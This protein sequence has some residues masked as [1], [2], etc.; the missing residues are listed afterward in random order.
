MERIGFMAEKRKRISRQIWSRSGIILMVF[1]LVMCA[2][3]AKLAYLQIA[4]HEYYKELVVNEITMETEVNPERG[5]I[6]DSTGNI[7]ATNKT[8]YLCFIS[9]QDIIDYVEEAT[10]ERAELAA[11]AAATGKEFEDPTMTKPFKTD[12]GEYPAMPIAQGISRFLSDTLDVEYEKILEKTAKNGRRYE[13][14]KDKIDEEAAK[15]IREFIDE[16]DL[17]RMIYLRAGSIRY[18]P[19]N[20]LASHVL[21]LTNA[22]G[23]GTYGLEAYYNNLL[24]GTSGRYVTAQDALNHE[25]GFEY[26]TFIEAE[27]GYNIVT[28]IDTYIQYELEN[29]LNATVKENLANN[30]ATG[31][32]MNV[33]TGAVLGM[34]TSP[35]FDCN[36]PYELDELSLAKLEKYDGSEE[37]TEDAKK[38]AANAVKAEEKD[39]DEESEEFAAKALAYYKDNRDELTSQAYTNKKYELIYAMWKN[40]AITELYEPGSTSKIITTAM[41]FE[42]GVVSPTDMF[43]C[44]GALKVDGYPKPISCHDHRGHGTVTYARGLQQSC[45]PT[46]MQAAF[47]LGEEKFYNY[48][49]RFGYTSITGIDLPGETAGLYSSWKDFSHV[50]L[51]VYSFGQTYKTTPIQQIAAIAAVANGGKYV[52]PHFLSEVV[53]DDGNVIDEYGT[54]VKR[55]VVSEEVCKTISEILEDGVSGDGGA[56]NAYVKGYKIAA[57]TGTS[58]KRDIKDE[59]LRVSSTVAYAPYDDPEIAILVMVDE[60][61]G[62][63]VYG[64]RVAAPYVSKFLANV[65][66]Y[67]GYEPQY[68]EEELATV[69]INVRNYSGYS[70][71]GAKDDIE[72]RGLICEVIGEGETVISQ[73]PTEGSTVTKQ[74][75][76]IIL[77]TGEE[78]AKA[79]VTVPDVEGK[80]GEAAMRILVNAGLNV[81][82]RGAKDSQSATV[83][84]Q[85]V[86]AGTK[87]ARGTVI[88]ISIVHTDITDG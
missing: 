48:F 23:V 14:I 9:P 34:A 3:I 73:V 86:E 84:S 87:V 38:L 8:V 69:D 11:D 57:K 26:E 47:R 32:V 18:Y 42:E 20:E 39:L 46:L 28:T 35:G 74:H 33:K 50:S 76:R 19:Y 88:E 80:T 71:M 45:N 78:S 75:G 1:G 16:N 58:E 22:D 63:V 81:R 2:V 52:T 49:E 5:T 64:S 70:V 6:Y 56:K 43:T 68:T 27:N 54:D 12:K 85:S 10:A 21:G 44:V 41:V 37:H 53:D 77:Y 51:A 29:Q 72:G 79:T 25:M 36:K 17:T 30:R 65:L 66:P 59:T 83:I 15:K 82:L 55:Q 13:E 62:G 31:I 24:E 7:L 60:P 61:M 40:K 4:N 67:L